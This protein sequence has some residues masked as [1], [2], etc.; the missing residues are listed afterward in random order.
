MHDWDWLL[1]WTL[2]CLQS[3]G[4]FICM[5]L[6]AKLLA[7]CSHGGSYMNLVSEAA[8]FIV[9][10]QIASTWAGI[11][12]AEELQ[13]QGIDCNL[14]LLFSFA[15]VCILPLLSAG[16]LSFGVERTLTCFLGSPGVHPN[17]R[18]PFS[19]C[20]MMFEVSSMAAPSA[21]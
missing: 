13:K 2:P 1:S 15:Q 21:M 14:T 7:F 12:A 10:L 3:S 20:L 17:Y 11:R 18:R 19:L 4:L 9:C 8:L 16:T 5:F 6:L